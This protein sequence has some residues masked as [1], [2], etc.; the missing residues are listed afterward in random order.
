M[1]KSEEVEKK[2]DAVEDWT[3]KQV[4]SKQASEIH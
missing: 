3:K 2:Y 4:V 1:L